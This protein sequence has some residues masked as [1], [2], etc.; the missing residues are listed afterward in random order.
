MNSE[1]CLVVRCVSWID[2]ETPTLMNGRFTQTAIKAWHHPKPSSPTKRSDSRILRGYCGARE[3]VTP[4]YFMLRPKACAE[5]VRA[6]YA[7]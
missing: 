6:E 1:E 2:E 4:A 7:S 5:E 3:F